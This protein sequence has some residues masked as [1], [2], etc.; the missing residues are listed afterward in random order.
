MRA[1]SFSL[2]ALLGLLLAGA[3]SELQ[4]QTGSKAAAAPSDAVK[5]WAEVEKSNEPPAPPAAWK[6]RQPTRDEVVAFQYPFL[7]NAIA[8]NRDFYTRFP[9]DTNAADANQREY[10][11][12]EIAAMRM[13]N[14]NWTARLEQLQKERMNDPKFA[15]DKRFKLKAEEVEKAAM[16]QQTNGMAAVF[17]EYEKGTR[18]LQKEFPDRPEIYQMLLEVAANANPEKTRQLVHEIMAG[19]ASE[20]VK[21]RAESILKKMELVG[22]PLAIKF[23]AVDG[24][25]VDVAK[26]A[27]KVVL[28]DFWATWCGPCVQELPHVKETYDKWHPHGFEIVGISFDQDKNALT[29][30]VADKKMAWPQYFDGEGWGNKFGKEFGITGIPAMWLVDKKGNLRDLNGREDL[31][32]KVEKLLGEK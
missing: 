25:E 30:F 31:S 21:E 23:T 1:P 24:R 10:D 8:R 26:M 5:A 16:V 28:V 15:A 12:V 4:A 18:Q 11:L 9:G 29:K 19:K 27:G 7:T 2:H 6:E 3:T 20:E 32:G 13:G 14:T 17:A 22:K